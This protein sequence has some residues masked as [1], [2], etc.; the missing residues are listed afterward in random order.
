[1]TKS[2]NKEKKRSKNSSISLAL[3]VKRSSLFFLSKTRSEGS[4]IA[5]LRTLYS[6]KPSSCKSN[7]LLIFTNCPFLQSAIILSSLK[8]TV[9]TYITDETSIA[10]TVGNQVDLVFTI[11]FT[12][13]SMTKILSIGLVYDD[14]SYLR[15]DWS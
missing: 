10:Y 14:G 11:I 3:N 9:D 8:L 13:E 4:F 1:M 6:T 12:L 15:D 2:K 7:L 5:S